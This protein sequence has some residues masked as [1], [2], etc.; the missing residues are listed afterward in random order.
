M[1]VVGEYA[2][3]SSEIKSLV[4]AAYAPAAAGA[5]C[6]YLSPYR[7]ERASAGDAI[8]HRLTLSRIHPA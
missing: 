4:L 7:N 2:S 5:R 8:T 6:E 3:I 1:A